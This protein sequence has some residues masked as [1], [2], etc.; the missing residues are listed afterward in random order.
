MKSFSFLSVLFLVCCAFSCSRE[1]PVDFSSQIKPIINA[2]CISCH[3]GVKKQGGFSLLFEE[4]ALAKLKSGNYGIV[5]GDASASEMIKRLHSEDPEERMPYLEEKL[6]DEEIELLTRWIDEGAQW[7]RHWAYDKVEEVEVPEVSL[8]WGNT[9]IDRFIA[10]QWDA[11]ALSPSA[12]A[13]PEILARRVALDIIGFPAPDSLK[14]DFLENPDN[15]HYEAFVDKLLSSPFYG[16]KWTSMWLDLARY[17]D[18]KG[19]ERDFGR[20]IWEYR[21]WLIRAFN[22]DKPYDVFLTEQLAGDL[23]PNPTDDQLLAT[24]FQRNSMTN[25][26]GGTDNEEF[27]VAAVLDRVNTVWEGVLSTT[28]ACVQCHS[29]PYD[30]FR[31]EEYYQFAAFYNNSLDYDTFEDYPLL[32]HLNQEQ[33]EKLNQYA[34]WLSANKHSEKEVDAMVKFIKT[35]SPA[36]YSVI[37]KDMKNAALVDTKW[38]AMRNPSSTR[39]PGF[40]FNGEN[41]LLLRWSK[42]FSGGTFQIHLDS[43]NGP[44]LANVR[45]KKSEGRVAENIPIVPTKGKHDLYF[46]YSHPKKDDGNEVTHLQFDW[47]YLMNKEEQNPAFWEL[48]NA[49]VPSTPIMLENPDG[50]HR[51]TH[52]FERGNWTSLGEEV[53]PMVP[54]SL[55][56]WPKGAPQN[57]LGLAQWIV[58]DANP[59]TARTMVNRV[60]EQ[61]FGYGLVETLEDMGTQGADPTHR[62]LLDYL[63]YKFMHEYKWSMKRLVKEIVISSVY[64]QSSELVPE[65]EKLDPNNKYLSYMPRVRLSAEQIRDQALF[66]SGKLNPE[67][68]GKPVMP[69]QPKGIWLSPYGG[70]NWVKSKGEDQ[71]RRAIYTFWKRTSPYPS[72][73][74]FD[75]VGREVCSARRIRTNTPLQALTLLNDSA[76]VDMANALNVQ[77]FE[78]KKPVEDK[79]AWAYEQVCQRSVDAER[80]ARL[81]GLYAQALEAYRKEDDLESPMY[82]GLSGKEKPEYAAMLVVCNALLN[83]DETLTKN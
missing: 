32:R 11:N 53:E 16:E 82:E 77:L 44:L 58:S 43:L 15:A 59:L 7:G 76:Y 14:A 17:A 41:T 71:Y 62:E 65:K 9:P 40:T 72:M 45:V 3:G 39:L 73:M 52:V 25:D 1:K 56:P 22:E 42:R 69:Y 33:S 79:I 80:K 55:N 68:Y 67:M 63:S 81:A 10:A 48:L 6:S 20:Q 74:S 34:E 24:A 30:P 19:Y 61:I 60:W 50:F 57:R 26:E 2:K 29:H 5:P 83:L 31:H 35:L 12:E 64:R 66:V 75:G 37:A 36:R 78:M 23:L 51:K 8:D 49:N 13:A 70:G 47:F 4:E 18:T 54:K 27:R 46:T 38:L 28:F 21:D